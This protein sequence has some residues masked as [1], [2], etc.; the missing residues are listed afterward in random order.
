M[1]DN[2]CDNTPVQEKIHCVYV[3]GVSNEV[4]SKRPQQNYK[5]SATSTLTEKA[6]SDGIV[7]ARATEKLDGTCCLID[8]FKGAKKREVL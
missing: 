3:I 2:N 5:V 8:T 1:S 6:V 4:S 7:N